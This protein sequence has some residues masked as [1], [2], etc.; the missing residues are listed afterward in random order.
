MQMRGTFQAIRPTRVTK[1]LS[2]A[3]RNTRRVPIDVL[4]VRHIRFKTRTDMNVFFAGES[5]KMF[6]M[7]SVKGEHFA[8][9]ERIFT[10]FQWAHS[11]FAAILYLYLMSTYL[12]H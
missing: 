1:S 6:L 12:S 10:D 5:V 11:H 8:D 2:Y 9:N 3:Q 7:E 4:A